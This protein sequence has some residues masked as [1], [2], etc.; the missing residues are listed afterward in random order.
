MTV[1]NNSPASECQNCTMQHQ[2]AE[3]DSRDD[4]REDQLGGGGRSNW[5]NRTTGERKGAAD[6]EEDD[7]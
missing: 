2:R 3:V 5:L 1:S 7:V 6:G 4:F